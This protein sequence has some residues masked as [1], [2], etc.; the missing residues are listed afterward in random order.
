[1]D[2]AL[3]DHR[4]DHRA[5][6]IDH[7][8]AGDRHGPGIGV[9]LD[10]GDMGAVGKGEI[11][12]VVERGFGRAGL[13][14]LV[15]VVMRDV[16]A[17][18]HR[19]ERHGTVGA[20]DGERAVG[21]RDVAFGDLQLIGDDAPGFLDHLVSGVAQRRA[22]HREREPNVPAPNWTT[23]VSPSTISILSSPS[24]NRSDR[25][26]AKVVAW[27]WPWLCVPGSARRLPW[28]STRSSADS[29]IASRPPKVPSR[30]EGATP[31][32]ST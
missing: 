3:D 13:Q 23:A 12:R 24:L 11:P 18:G 14:A 21:E 5:D 9:S 27:P 29:N 25:I 30:R 26:W 8:V 32:D 6:I 2:L 31:E 10:F 28:R 22:A 4:V 20:G 1:M 16:R 7:T 17:L 19:G 15:R